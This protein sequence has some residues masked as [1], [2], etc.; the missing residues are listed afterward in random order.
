MID[1]AAPEGF[2]GRRCRHSADGIKGKAMDEFKPG[3]HPRELNNLTAIVEEVTRVEMQDDET[4]MVQVRTA[5]VP[6]GL[7][8][9][10]TLLFDLDQFARAFNL[11]L[12]KR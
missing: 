8:V 12:R 2:R 3:P 6:E 4:M 11:P 10:V 7:S 1:S 9:P 5:T